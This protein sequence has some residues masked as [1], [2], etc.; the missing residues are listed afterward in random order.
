MSSLCPLCEQKASSVMNVRQG[1]SWADA[2]GLPPHTFFS[3]YVMCHA[4]TT[5]FGDMKVFC[6]TEKDL[7]EKR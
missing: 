6:H 4:T 2:A 7:Q 1:V 3:K 5:Q